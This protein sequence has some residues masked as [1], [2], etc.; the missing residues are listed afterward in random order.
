MQMSEPKPETG[1]APRPRQGV[2]CL[3][4]PFGL[5]PPAPCSLEAAKQTIFSACEKEG[6]GCDEQTIS[7]LEKQGTGSSVR[8]YFSRRSGW[9]LPRDDI[10]H[11]EDQ[12]SKEGPAAVGA[13]ISASS[14][15]LENEG[16]GSSKGGYFFRASSGWIVPKI[17]FVKAG[18]SVA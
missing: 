14:S 9:I 8:S 15:A 7:A 10:S 1:S 6:S 16:T 11:S 2:I 12:W 13:G 3:P 5:G 18:S 4:G 17:P